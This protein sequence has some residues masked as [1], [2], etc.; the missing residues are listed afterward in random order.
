MQIAY[1]TIYIYIYAD[2]TH[3]HTC[4]IYT[5]DTFIHSHIVQKCVHCSTSIH[6]HHQIKDAHTRVQLNWPVLYAN[7]NPDAHAHARM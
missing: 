3:T 4:I 6:I 7:I 5:P 1:I 2:K